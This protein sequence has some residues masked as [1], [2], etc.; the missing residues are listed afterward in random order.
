M[1]TDQRLQIQR[2]F[3][4]HVIHSA[5]ELADI[6][7]YHSDIQMTLPNGTL[8]KPFS[9]APKHYGI[10]TYTDYTPTNSMV[11]R[12]YVYLYMFNVCMR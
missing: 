6:G 7:A 3:A 1:K 4:G 12:T 5:I 9:E 8:R 10:K 2:H 11:R